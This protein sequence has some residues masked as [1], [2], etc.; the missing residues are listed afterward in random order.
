MDDV[1]RFMNGWPVRRYC[2]CTR[3]SYRKQWKRGEGGRYDSKVLIFAI[4]PSESLLLNPSILQQSTN[5]LSVE[6]QKSREQKKRKL[7]RND[8]EG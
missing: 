6:A 2:R 8:D 7:D 5:T 1:Y 4:C 3:D